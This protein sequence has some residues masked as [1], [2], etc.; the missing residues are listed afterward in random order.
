MSLHRERVHP[1]FV[2]GCFG[3]KV[4]TVQLNAG[5][6]NSS[7]MVSGRKW[8]A[9]IDAYKQARAEGIQPAGTSMKA[10]EAARKASDTLGRAYDAGSMIAANRVNERSA[11]LM[12]YIDTGKET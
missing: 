3:C 6:A 9:E 7:K 2:E 12:N 4:S 8:N 5:D 11:K 1:E 10:V